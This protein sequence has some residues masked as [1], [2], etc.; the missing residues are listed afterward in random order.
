MIIWGKEYD[1]IVGPDWSGLGHTSPS[2]SKVLK[3]I[4]ELVLDSDHVVYEDLLEEVRKVADAKGAH[5]LE[6]SEFG[7]SVYRR[8]TGHKYSISVLKDRRK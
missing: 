8:S 7:F 6:V 1:S 2:D 3:G 4:W 5:R